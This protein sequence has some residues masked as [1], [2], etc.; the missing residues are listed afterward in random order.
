MPTFKPKNLKKI[1]VS[2]KNITT[3]DGKHK[4]IIETINTMK[5]KE[6]PRLLNEKMELKKVLKKFYYLYFHLG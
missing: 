3:L 4:E 2:K 5:E 6:L 1:I